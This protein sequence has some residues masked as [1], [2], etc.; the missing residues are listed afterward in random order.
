[1]HIIEALSLL[2]PAAPHLLIAGSL[3]V[4]P[5]YV[6]ELIEC[7]RSHGVTAR[8]HWLGFLD[9]SSKADAYAAADIFVHASESEGMA[10]AILEAMDVGLPVV[11]TRGCYMANAAAAE[12]LVQCEQGPAALAKSLAPFVG[13]VQRGRK[14]GSVGQAYV[15]KVHAW[16]T[17]ASETLKIYAE[18]ASRS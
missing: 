1:V 7:A 9:E 11:A 3:N 4:E 6:A 14:Q 15:R 17:I 18:G 2:G 10:L 16:E 13:D 8:V 12:A 5:L